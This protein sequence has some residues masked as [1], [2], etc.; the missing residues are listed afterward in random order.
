[1]AIVIHKLYTI[2]RCPTVCV[3]RRRYWQATL[4]FYLHFL[5]N[6]YAYLRWRRSGVRFVGQLM[7]Y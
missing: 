6:A 1:M 3:T 4:L 7:L 5:Q 2:S